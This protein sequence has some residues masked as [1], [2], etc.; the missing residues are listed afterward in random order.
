MI[1]RIVSDRRFDSV[2]DHILFLIKRATYLSNDRT[3]K[4]IGDK[5]SDADDTGCRDVKVGRELHSVVQDDCRSLPDTEPQ[6]K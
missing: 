2:D 4:W 1:E 6:L 3:N 5:F